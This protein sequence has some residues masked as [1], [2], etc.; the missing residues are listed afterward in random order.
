MEARLLIEE[1]GRRYGRAADGHGDYS[2][3][4][5]AAYLSC[6]NLLHEWRSGMVE[7]DKSYAEPKPCPTTKSPPK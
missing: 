3:G 5:A 2:R 1:V 7:G 4:M 6:L